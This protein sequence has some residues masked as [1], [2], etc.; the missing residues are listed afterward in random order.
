MILI[1]IDNPDVRRSCIQDLA[2]ENMRVVIKALYRLSLSNDPDTK[3]A[4]LLAGI[5]TSQMQ[6]TGY[7]IEDEKED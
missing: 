7:Y 1:N 2:P 5:L 6:L 3:Q 4:D